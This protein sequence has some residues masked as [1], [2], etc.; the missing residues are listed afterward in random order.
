MMEITYGDINEV[1]GYRVG[2]RLDVVEQYRVKPVPCLKLL[3]KQEGELYSVVLWDLDAPYGCWDLRG[4]PD[5]RSSGYLHWW[6]ANID[7][8]NNGDCENADELAK[9][10]SPNPPQETMNHR[11]MFYLFKQGKKIKMESVNIRDRANFP[12]DKIVKKYEMELLDQMG[13]VVTTGAPIS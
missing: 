6:V 12:I 5:I 2:W 8:N 11:Y 7:F 4:N 1:G 10:V 13:F 9:Y 3:K